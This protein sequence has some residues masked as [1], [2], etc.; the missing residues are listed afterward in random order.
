MVLKKKQKA[1]NCT[2]A[3]AKGG[4]HG[5]LILLLMEKALNGKQKPLEVVLHHIEEY[6][7]EI[8]KN[9]EVFSRQQ[10]LSNLLQLKDKIKEGSLPLHPYAYFTILKQIEEKL[11]TK[12]RLMTDGSV[13]YHRM[14]DQLKRELAQLP[15][16]ISD[17][18]Q[19]HSNH[20]ISLISQELQKG[21][22]GHFVILHS[23][24]DHQRLL[25]Y[26][27]VSQ[28]CILTPIPSQCQYLDEVLQLFPACKHPYTNHFSYRK[29]RANFI[30]QR[31]IALEPQLT[32]EHLFFPNEVDALKAVDRLQ[33]G[34]F[35]VY[36]RSPKHYVLLIKNHV[37]VIQGLEISANLDLKQQ[38]AVEVLNERIFYEV[39]SPEQVF[40]T[41]ERAVAA[42]REVTNGFAVIQTAKD[43]YECIYKSG[44]KSFLQFLPLDPSKNLFA[45]LRDVLNEVGAS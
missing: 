2:F 40:P 36:K 45:E 21:K 16:S 19:C 6:A 5:Q 32:S 15:L 31:N 33:P 30:K 29:L 39:L 28:R 3:S 27:D 37:D 7:E 20:E 26:K 38:L 35:A 12:T 14:D 23:N 34:Q 42:L 18:E 1:K 9:W 11:E 10:A 17:C 43:V 4:F 44:D 8:Y 13:A 25:L 22:S 24:E 41:K